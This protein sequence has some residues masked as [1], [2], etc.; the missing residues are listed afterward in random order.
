MFMQYLKKPDGSFDLLPK[1]NVDFGGGLE[2]I[3]MAL[4]GV[5]DIIAVCHWP[6]IEQLERTSGKNYEHAT[7]AD[8]AAFRIV[9]DHVKAAVFLIGDGVVPSNSERGYF[10]RRLLRRA[11]RYAD[12]LGMHEAKLSTLVGPAVEP[13]RDAYPETYAAREM[14]EQEIN[15]EEE[16]FRKT[17]R[18]GIREFEKLVSKVNL[19][20]SFEI[21]GAANVPDRISGKEAFDLYQ[22]YGFPIELILE[23][24]KEKN[25]SIDLERFNEEFDKHKNLS[26]TA[27][28]GVFKGG[29]ADASEQTT[30]LHTTHHLLL[31]ALQIVLGP[32]VKQRGSNI[33]SERLRLDFIYDKK[34]TEEEKREAERI[35]NEKIAEDLP[36]IRSELAREEAEKLGAE[37]EFGQ[38]YPDRV[39]VYS[40]GPKGATPEDPQFDKAFSIEFCGGPHVTHTGDIG[41]FTLAKEEASSAGVRRIRGVLAKGQ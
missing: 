34:M 1:R 27:S 28:A 30:K 14:I 3:A 20:N 4:A 5:P 31:K 6:I 36:V 26:R 2:R 39:S 38:K 12:Q 37:H 13:Y 33:T 24:A 19:T 17:L 25:I 16:K 15:K 35:V 32:T 23:L 29:L 40:I 8:L 18:D 9:A 10:V 11:V 7:P 21:K 41:H 22:S